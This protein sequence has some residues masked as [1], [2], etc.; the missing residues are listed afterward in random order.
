M[1]LSIL[2]T[3]VLLSV[4]IHSFGQNINHLGFFPTVDHSGTLS[5][6]WS[7]G[8][9]YFSAFNAVNDK[10]EGK[11]DSPG[12]FIF[13]AEQSLSYQV[14]KNLSFTGSYVFERLN[15]T[16][17]N[18]RNENRIYFQTTYKP[19]VNQTELKFRA[20]YD[21]RFIQD[22]ETGERP[23]TSRVRALVGLSRPIGSNGKYY[24]SAYNEWFFNTFEDAAVVYG[25]NWAY[26]GVGLKT[27]KLGAFEVGPLYIAWVT[28][29][30]RDLQNFYY[31]QLT[32]I[33]HLDLRK[34][35]Q[36]Q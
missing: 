6:K 32:W 14:S 27:N 10:I 18:Y 22:R 25:E 23:Y 11:A 21:A 36:P 5:N 13:Y 24:F 8:I 2:T 28:N 33:T 17:S 29:K 35:K 15:P 9:Y 1:K 12:Y 7:Y 30:E 20:R 26:A 31:L 4:A 19:K 3:I 16:K 34:N